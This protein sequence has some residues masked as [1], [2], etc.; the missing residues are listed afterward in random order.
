MLNTGCWVHEPAYLGRSPH[1]SPY[2]AGF[3]ALLDDGGSPQL[4]NLLNG[5][6]AR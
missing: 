6:G 4:V 2:R 1:A 5:L 3:A